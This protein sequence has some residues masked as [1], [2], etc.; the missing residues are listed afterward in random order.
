MNFERRLFCVLIVAALLVAGAMAQVQ[1]AEL[2]VTVKDAKGA[3]VSGATVTAAEPEKGISKQRK[4][5][6]GRNGDPAVA[7]SRR[8]TR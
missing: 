3:V 4:T 7:A 5:D 1:T 6:G 2:H 8:S